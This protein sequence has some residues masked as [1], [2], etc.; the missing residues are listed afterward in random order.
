MNERIPMWHDSED[1]DRG[2]EPDY[3]M[4]PEELEALVADPKEKHMTTTPPRQ[5]TDIAPA[6]AIDINLADDLTITAPLNENGERC[7]WPWEPQQLVAAPIGQYRCSYCMAMVVA[8]MPH[9]D[10]SPEERTLSVEDFDEIAEWCGGRRS[11]SDHRVLVFGETDDMVEA[12]IGDVIR[13]DGYGEFTIQPA[14]HPT[15]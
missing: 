13:R 14:T 10:Y 2:A 9:I 7:P 12:R 11:V 1:R 3:W 8:G 6:D 5:W 15:P 4:P